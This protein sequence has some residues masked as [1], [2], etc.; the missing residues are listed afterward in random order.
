VSGEERSGPA[1]FRRALALI[2]H[3]VRDDEQGMQ[4][5]IDDEAIPADRLDWLAQAAVS[6]LWQLTPQLCTPARA[7]EILETLTSA[8]DAE[9][10]L[11]PANRLVA[12]LAMAQY[13]GDRAAID[14]V[15]REAADAPGG[16]VHFALTAAGA[17]VAML[18]ELRTDDGLQLLNHLAIKAAGDEGLNRPEPDDG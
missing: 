13:Y 12:R 3:G 15:L 14:E 16:L 17:V 1:D 7:A 5:I 8:P 4:A 18:P 11:D 2:L 6:I 9:E 10:L